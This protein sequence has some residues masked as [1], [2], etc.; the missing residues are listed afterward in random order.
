MTGIHRLKQTRAPRLT[1]AGKLRLG[2]MPKGAKF[3]TSL[4]KWRITSSDVDAL[5]AL[6]HIYGGTVTPF[7]NRS[8]PHTHE[9]YTETDTLSVVVPPGA[10]DVTPYTEWIKGQLV[11]TCDGETMTVR[12][13][14]KHPDGQDLIETEAPCRCWAEQVLRCNP[15]R[16]TLNV[17]LPE[18]PYS[19]VW[20]FETSSTNA[21]D[22]LA[23]TVDVL[24]LARS[25]GLPMGTLRIEQREA[26]NIDG[27]LLKFKVAV[28]GS[29]HSM[30]EIASGAGS[31]GALGASSLGD[32]PLPPVEARPEIGAAPPAPPET[33]APSCVICTEPAGTRPMRR[34]RDGYAHSDCIPDVL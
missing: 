4:D 9:L 18:I 7:G 19:G 12:T 32:L 16:L 5:D 30:N 11:R 21:M 28:L 31:L 22:E 15:N 6:A 33:G 26:R 29:S 25:Q 1:V 2:H 20:R 8:S 34:H 27:Q 23:G 10:L 13:V 14:E 3:P 24:D 17:I